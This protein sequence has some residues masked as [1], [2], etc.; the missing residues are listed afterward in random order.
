MNNT[1]P[2][3]SLPPTAADGDLY[4]QVPGP[5]EF[6]AETGPDASQVPNYVKRLPATHTLEDFQQAL[7]YIERQPDRYRYYGPTRD[8]AG[9]ALE[10]WKGLVEDDQYIRP[11]ILVGALLHV[12]DHYTDTITSEIADIVIDSPLGF[13]HGYRHLE[14]HIRRLVKLTTAAA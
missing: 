2:F 5:V 11:D 1:N 4:V 10:A 9:Q 13:E 8:I 3:A 7:A 12:I 14:G 6:D